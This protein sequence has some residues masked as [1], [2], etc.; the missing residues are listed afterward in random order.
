MF[1]VHI[2]GVEDR[3]HFIAIAHAAIQELSGAI[4]TL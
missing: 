4:N 1:V 2:Y 3:V